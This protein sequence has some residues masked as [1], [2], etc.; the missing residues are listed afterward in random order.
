MALETLK[1]VNEIDGFSV[2][3]M[4]KLRFQFPEKFN[5]SGAMDYEWFESDIRPN[6][7]IYIR[8]DKN[9]IAFTLQN[10][11][12]K[13]VG[14]NGCQVDTLIAAARG[15]LLGLNKNYPC[16]ENQLALSSL[17]DALRYLRER[18]E[19]RIARN[20]EGTNKI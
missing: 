10:G 19:N 5:D 11:R 14:V 18:K 4:D 1:G 7:F 15:I 13:V 9:S 17:K 2:V 16:T 20:V 12:A 3:D 8:Y 6:H